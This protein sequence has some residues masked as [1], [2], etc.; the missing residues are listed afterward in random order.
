ML[1]KNKLDYLIINT[2]YTSRI[3]D[4]LGFDKI[5]CIQENAFTPEHDE[6]DGQGQ[7]NIYKVGYTFDYRTEE[8]F[9]KAMKK[10]YYRMSAFDIR[11]SKD[12]LPK[13]TS[14]IESCVY[15]CDDLWGQG[16]YKISD[17]DAE[18]NKI[19]SILDKKGIS[20]YGTICFRCKSRK[21]ISFFKHIIEELGY[22]AIFNYEGDEYVDCEEDELIITIASFD[23]E[24]G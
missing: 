24:S 2:G 10:P 13:F 7:N 22:C 14:F 19:I 23:T 9:K 4:R 8:G 6:Y 18:I 21:D 16:L 3:I 11:Q 20:K 1:N 12:D 5:E 17:N 15:I